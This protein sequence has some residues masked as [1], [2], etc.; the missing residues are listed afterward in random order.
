MTPEEQALSQQ[1]FGGEQQSMG[2]MEAIKE[3]FKEVRDVIAPGLTWDKIIGDLG[4]EFKQ[5]GAHG[6]HEVAA[7]LFNGNAFVMYPRNSGKDDHGVHGPE[8]SPQQAQDGQEMQQEAPS[9]Q[10]ERGGRRM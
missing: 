3:A 5:Q 1:L 6:A 4:N 10:L 2:A 7:A 8:Q 9:Q